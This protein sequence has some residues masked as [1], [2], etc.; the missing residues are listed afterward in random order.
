MQPV[1]FGNRY[2]FTDNMEEAKEITIRCLGGKLTY[3]ERSEHC[4]LTDI[5]VDA[6]QRR[7]G[8]GS[9]LV[10][11]LRRRMQIVNKTVYVLTR[12]S[13][14]EARVFYHS[15]GLY[16]VVIPGLLAEGTDAM[17]YIDRERP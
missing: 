15:L 10:S 16:P 5:F 8:I 9:R 12:R 3:L 14:H 13:N 17:I 4:E 6:E 7:Q 2:P 11:E 1:D